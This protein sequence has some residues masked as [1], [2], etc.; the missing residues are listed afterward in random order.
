M[1]GY[2]SITFWVLYLSRATYATQN[3]LQVY[4]M[5]SFYDY[6]FVG[7]KE[8]LAC[9]HKEPANIEKIIAQHTSVFRPFGITTPSAP[10]I[11][12]DPTSTLFSI[13]SASAE[14]R[15]SAEKFKMRHFLSGCLRRER[16]AFCQAGFPIHAT[17]VAARR[18]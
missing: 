18:V 10:S 17:P 5:R 7:I 1:I 12:R 14:A 8:N 13:F 11:L 2:T 4:L 15:V 3:P 16:V 9:L 6:L